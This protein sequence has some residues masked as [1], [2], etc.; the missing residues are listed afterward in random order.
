MKPK[1]LIFG[2]LLA[3]LC[4][5]G[6]DSDDENIKLV[7]GITVTPANPDALE[8]G[9]ELE[10]TASFT[11]ADATEEII[12]VTW[13]DKILSIEGNGTKAKI[14]ALTFGE[15]RIFATNKS[16]IVVSPDIAIKI[17]SDDYAALMVGNYLGTGSSAMGP[18]SDINI[19]LERV[20]I[21]NS[22]LK[23]TVIAEMTGFGEQ[24][25]VAETVNISLGN[26]PGTYGLNGN[27]ELNIL[28]MIFDFDLNGSVFNNADKS[29][30]LILD[31]SSNP[32]M[33]LVIEINAVPGEATDY[34]ASAAGDYIGEANGES[35]MGPV[36][37]L[38][39]EISI[40]R[41]SSSRVDLFIQSP[42]GDIVC[43]EDQYIEVDA[44]I[45]ANT[46]T[47]N[48]D[49]TLV[50][51]FG[52]FPMTVTGEINL[53]EH[54]LTLSLFAEGMG[55]TIMNV[56]VTAEMDITKIVVGEYMANGELTG[57]MEMPLTDVPVSLTRV[58]KATVNLFAATALATIDCN[59]TVTPDGNFYALQGA[60]SILGMDFTVTGRHN[61]SNQTLTLSIANSALPLKIELSGVRVEN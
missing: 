32:I 45:A 38:E 47:L 12:W 40:T 15:T 22:T 43:K 48:G 26:Q 8:I 13:D 37:G 50:S 39:M 18:I 27:A 7:T 44:G 17:N 59:L 35:A 34:G 3:C 58:D 25:I 60:T 23:M 55:M 53:L 41:I 51:A 31:A 4:L 42:S 29:L 56:T 10:L 24:T 1:F 14:K 16:R 33:P 19:K 11:P 57:M 46:C 52:D 28:G 21:S 49:A 6:C 20:G 2:C 9:D 36:S 54:K 30:K 5:S 61:P